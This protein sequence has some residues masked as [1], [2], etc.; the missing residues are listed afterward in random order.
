MTE[1]L[2]CWYR[3]AMAVVFEL[4]GVDSLPVYQYKFLHSFC[5][6]DISRNKF[7]MLFLF[8]H[9]VILVRTGTYQIN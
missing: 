4:E 8:Y 6:V 1:H 9:F 5:R 7:P 3:L 2:H